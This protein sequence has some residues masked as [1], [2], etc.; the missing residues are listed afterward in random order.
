MRKRNGLGGEEDQHTKG[1]PKKK[2]GK[3]IQHKYIPREMNLD[4]AQKGTMPV[5]T[6]SD[7]F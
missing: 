6:T 2:A 5:E 1:G 3:K 4:H 7:N